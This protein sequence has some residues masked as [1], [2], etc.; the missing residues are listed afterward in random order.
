M[1]VCLVGSE[2]TKNDFYWLLNWYYEINYGW[3]ELKVNWFMFGYIYY[4]LIY[5]KHNFYQFMFE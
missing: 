1:C 2:V 3:D 5:Q 4:L